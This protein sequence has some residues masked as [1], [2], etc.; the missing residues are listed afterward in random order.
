MI[1]VIIPI[2]NGIQYINGIIKNLSDCYYE[3]KDREKLEVIFVNDNPKEDIIINQQFNEIKYTIRIIQNNGNKG[4]HYS[5]VRGLKEAKG[6][7]VLFLDQDD[8]IKDRYFVSQLDKIGD[9]AVV[10][11]N[12]KYRQNREIIWNQQEAERIENCE[13]YFM[14]L[15]GIVSPGQALI[16]KDKIPK[17]WKENILLGNYCDDAFLWLLMKD[18]GEKFIVNTEQLFYHNEDGNNNS[19][20]WENTANA[21]EEMLTVVQE[22]K[23]IT[24]KHLEKLE[25]CVKEKANKHRKYDELEQCFEW[26]EKNTTKLQEYVEKYPLYKIAVYGYGVY[27]KRLLKCLENC[28]IGVSYVIDQ[29]AGAFETRHIEVKKIQDKL[30]PVDLVIIT[31]V[32]DEE[33]IKKELRC[34]SSA[35]LVTVN[36]LRRLVMEEL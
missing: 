12:G 1:S 15:T 14:T 25:I 33:N 6:E 26:I 9:N 30:E 27:G 29:N 11:C 8:T 19:F 35:K 34:V 4:I 24:D 5:R 20:Q 13:D 10:I 16:R 21:L 2:Y 7:Y 3:I 18:K 28:N 31:P 32:F 22:K 23:L 17:E 36:E